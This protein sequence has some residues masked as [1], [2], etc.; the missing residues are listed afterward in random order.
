LIVSDQCLEF[1]LL[2]IIGMTASVSKRC[3]GDSSA[4]K[5][6]FHKKCK[7]PRNDYPKLFPKEKIIE[8]RKRGNTWLDSL[9][10]I[11]E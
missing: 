8:C 5:R 11:F 7:C 4:A 9:L 10:N 1:E 2:K 6:E 3:R